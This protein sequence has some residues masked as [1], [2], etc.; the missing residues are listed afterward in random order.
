MK[1]TTE[2]IATAASC[3]TDGAGALG[4]WMSQWR[5]IAQAARSLGISRTAVYGLIARRRLDS[6]EIGG[7]LMVSAFDIERHRQ[8]RTA[9]TRGAVES[10]NV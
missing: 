10:A 8:R 2:I 1:G 3:H 4:Q 6:V 9:R 5:S 7:R